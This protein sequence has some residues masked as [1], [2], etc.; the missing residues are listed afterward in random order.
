MFFS[1]RAFNASSNSFRWPGDNAFLLFLML[2]MRLCSLL[3]RCPGVLVYLL[4]R[5]E[6]GKRA[7]RN[8]DGG[9]HF[10]ARGGTRSLAVSIDFFP[11]TVAAWHDPFT[12]Q[13]LR[14]CFGR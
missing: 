11:I 6:P 5:R 9:F 14:E 12:S 10:F 3:N 7:K 8:E 1:K 4:T 2:A 13:T